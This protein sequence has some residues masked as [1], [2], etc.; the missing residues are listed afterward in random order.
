MGAHPS[1]LGRIDLF[2][3]GK[4][5]SDASNGRHLMLKGIRSMDFGN[6]RRA[7]RDLTGLLRAIGF[8]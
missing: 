3:L 5:L 1:F 7:D 4:P 8:G 2:H 6:A